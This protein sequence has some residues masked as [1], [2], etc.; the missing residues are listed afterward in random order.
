MLNPSTVCLGRQINILF[1]SSGKKKKKKKEE[2][3]SWGLLRPSVG[4]FLLPIITFWVWYQ[5]NVYFLMLH[6]K[7]FIRDLRN[8]ILSR[9]KVCSSALFSTWIFT[10]HLC[11]SHEQSGSVQGAFSHCVWPLANSIKMT[12]LQWIIS[13]LKANCWWVRLMNF[14]TS[15]IRYS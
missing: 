13:K 15:S 6:N 5:R 4:I 7:Y 9:L 3:L 12:N 11:F 14:R 1:Q 8:N 2:G 10:T